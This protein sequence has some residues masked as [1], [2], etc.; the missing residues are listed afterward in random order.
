MRA[1]AGWRVGLL[2]AV[3]LGVVATARAQ[4]A[5]PDLSN[6]ERAVRNKVEFFHSQATA[7][8]DDGALWGKYGMVL[9]AHGF[10]EQALA[11]YRHA[12]LQAP[13]SFRWA[14]YLAAQLETSAPNEAVEWY[15]RAIAK[16]PDYAPAR[17]R[18]G[19]TLET[20][21]RDEE[22]RAQFEQAAAIDPSNLF[23]PLGLGRIALRRG[24]H[25]G[26]V[27][28]LER[29]YALDP[30]VHG[31][32]SALARAYHRTGRR[33]EARQLAESARDMGRITYLPDQLR[34]E[35]NQ[36][37]VDRS[38]FLRRARTFKDN[39]RYREAMAQLEEV[40]EV[41]PEYAEAH[42]FAAEVLA[43]MQDHGSSAASARRALELDP[44]IP[45]ARSRLAMALF[46]IGDLP[47]AERQARLSLESWPRDAR[48]HV[49][50][51]MVH[52]DRN[53]V[54]P[55]VAELRRAAAIPGRE[56]AT[57]RVLIELIVQVGGAYADVGERGAA[58][59]MIELALAVAKEPGGDTSRVAELERLLA[60]HRQR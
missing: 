29:A 43:Q 6:A 25:Q 52:A 22:A 1:R 58:V 7:A 45:E 53:E 57:T 15:E 47:E 39:G 4:V 27:T 30:N 26:A 28:H 59:E 20:L 41:H 50:L 11:A 21:A 8:I 3:C 54:G 13:E 55:A 36:E 24:D 33:D 10:V 31:T 19:R 16:Q 18:L 42:L 2:T 23:A 9:E 12:A 35:I 56:P 37:A 17:I 34:S 51:S 5:L 40:L 38:S 46:E 32:V 49:L 48:L 44:D 14:Y 60:S